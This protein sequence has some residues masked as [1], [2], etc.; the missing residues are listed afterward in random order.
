MGKVYIINNF[1]GFLQ[2]RVTLLIWNVFV[3]VGGG[4]KGQKCTIYQYDM[5]SVHGV[6]TK[7]RRFEHFF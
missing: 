7:Q 3:R 2:F 1:V 5:I 6:Y 4:L